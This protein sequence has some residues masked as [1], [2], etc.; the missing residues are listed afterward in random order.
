MENRIPRSGDFFTLNMQGFLGCSLPG[1]LRVLRGLQA[2]STRG[3]VAGPALPHQ[4]LQFTVAFPQ[5]LL[6]LA[7]SISVPDRCPAS[8]PTFTLHNSPSP[9]GLRPASVQ[10]QP[11]LCPLLSRLPK[12]WPLPPAHPASSPCCS[13]GRARPRSCR[14]FPQVAVRGAGYLPI[15]RPLSTQRKAS[16]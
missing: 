8:S 11:K 10:M 14:V 6:G 15:P 3:L 1:I 9:P 12:D 16:C 5:S 13:G 4:D 7:P 2:P